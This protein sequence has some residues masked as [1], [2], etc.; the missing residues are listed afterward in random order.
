LT[1][2]KLVATFLALIA[3]VPCAFSQQ[4]TVT[5]SALNF[6]P[7]LISAVA[8]GS[9]AQNVTI[10]NTGIAN[11]IVTSVLASGGYKQTDNCSTI[12]PGQSC[13]VT[14]TFN[15]GTLGSI[16]GAITIND[17]A[18]SSPQVVSLSGVGIAP[19]QL[20]PGLA[21]F[22]TIPVGSSSL[23]RTVT[24]KALS[25]ASLSINQISVSGN[26]AQVNNCPSSLQGGQSCTIQVIFHPTVNKPVTG[27]LAVST[28]I[29]TT[30]LAFSVALT[31]TG[32]GTVMSQIALQPA[33]L[34]FGNKG[35]DLVDSVKAVTLTNTSSTSVT[36]DNVSLTGSP[37]AVG[38][39]PLYKIN[40]NTCSG[41]L[42][43][44]AQCK[45]QVAFS[46]TFSRVFPQSYPAALT[47]TDSDPTSPQVIGISGKQVEQLTLRTAS[48]IFPPQ[49]VGT[50]TTKTVTLTGHDLQ[51][52][53]LLDM[54][55][56]GD[57]SASGDLAPCLLHFGGRCTMNIT[58]SP[59]QSGAINGSVT[60]ETYPECNP[61]PL[62][63]CS[64]PVVLN[65]SG[66]GQ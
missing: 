33:T 59:K 40:S 54:V 44:S 55:T 23:P 58:F 41:M 8:S 64:D 36:I 18:A 45:I 57:F 21:N 14:V 65:L 29:G 63:Q 13:S 26:F 5:P 20:T 4:V 47:I 16:N 48:I 11:V 6:P 2:A 38:A 56:S 34:N 52:G 50:T 62:H 3:V 66:T 30:P 32:S 37:N 1:H 28:V 17:N 43:P 15:P 19:V 31:G 53:L 42:A 10:T 49:A 12:S 39:F 25:S 46:T 7:Q 51:N 22:G 24:L 27:A 35:P 9:H 60:I 61:F